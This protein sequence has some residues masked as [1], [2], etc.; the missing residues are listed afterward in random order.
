MPRTVQEILSQADILAK[1]FEAD[2]LGP[3][4]TVDGAPLRSVRRAFDDLARA[5]ERLAEAVSIARWHGHSWAA[6]GG[7]LGTSGEAARQRYRTEASPGT[8]ADRGWAEEP[9]SSS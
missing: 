8:P 9:L 1:Q 4:T 6:I 5:Q 7:M 2:D 3:G